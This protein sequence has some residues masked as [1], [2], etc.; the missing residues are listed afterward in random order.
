MDHLNTSASLSLAALQ[1]AMARLAAPSSATRIYALIDNAVLQLASAEARRAWPLQGAYS[2]FGE[3]VAESARRAGP[4][5]VQVPTEG[6]PSVPFDRDTG[7]LFGSFIASHLSPMELTRQLAPLLDVRLQDGLEMVMRFFDARILPS[8]LE[9]VA[10]AVREFVGQSVA[11]W[12][13]WD[14]SYTLRLHRFMP[15]TEQ[16]SMTYPIRLSRETEARLLDACF[17]FTLIERFRNED[18]HLLDRLPH[19]QRYPFFQEQIKRAARYGLTGLADLE[20]YVTLALSNGACF[21]DHSKM[22]RVWD[23][24]AAGVPLTTALENTQ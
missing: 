15:A 11:C 16:G 6:P 20:I 2:L 17:P 8:W 23:S 3:S 19:A 13:Y 4:M 24:V 10:P 5:V 9:H 7:L 12:I 21:D 22:Q 18:P 14:H 1:D